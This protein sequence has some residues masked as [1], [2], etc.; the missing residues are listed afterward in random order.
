MSQPLVA[1]GASPSRGRYITAWILEVVLAAA[2]LAAGG[3]K[4]AG[5]P[6]M[7]HIFDRI[8]LGQWFRIAMGLVEVAGALALLIPGYAFFGAVWLAATM[9]GAVLVHRLVLPTP[10]APAVLLLTLDAA[11]AWLR[12]DQLSCLVARRR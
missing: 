1:P 2:Y 7:V 12:R 8:G 5:V 6:M 9:V 10:A 11:L 3:A 4:L